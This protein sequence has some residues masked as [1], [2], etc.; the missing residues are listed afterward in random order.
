[1]LQLLP[2]SDAFKTLHARL[3]SAPTL[4][5]LSLHSLG[6]GGSQDSVAA[7]SG[8]RK[9]RGLIPGSGGTR[10]GDRE[11]TEHGDN[12]ASNGGSIPFEQLLDLFRQRQV[13]TNLLSSHAYQWCA[14]CCRK[15]VTSNAAFAGGPRGRRGDEEK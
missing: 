8:Q 4:A 1:M 15:L 5:L 6:P 3:H 7:T 9:W 11:P 12:V 10:A 2:Q 13:R 14:L